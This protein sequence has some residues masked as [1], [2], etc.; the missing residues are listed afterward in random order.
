MHCPQRCGDS[1]RLVRRRKLFRRVVV[2]YRLDGKLYEVNGGHCS[3]YGLEGQWE[4]AET[5]VAALK[6]RGRPSDWYEGAAEATAALLG[7]L[8]K[9]R[10]RARRR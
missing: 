9:L 1:N 4:P 6:M 2:A 10:L 5:S 3:C 7:L 8:K